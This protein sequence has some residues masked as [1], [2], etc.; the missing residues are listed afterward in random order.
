MVVLLFSLFTTAVGFQIKIPSR[1]LVRVA[2]AQAPQNG[3]CVRKQV[4]TMSDVGSQ[5]VRKPHA[6]LLMRLRRFERRQPRDQ[7]VEVVHNHQEAR[8]RDADARRRCG[9]R[10][11]K[12]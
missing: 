9:R 6:V 5:E 4:R 12:T 2:I 7:R 10:D 8:E 1:K 3:Y 11:E